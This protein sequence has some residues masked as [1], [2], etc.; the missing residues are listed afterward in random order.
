MKPREKFSK[1]LR[2]SVD[3][4]KINYVEF[5]D[6]LGI[7]ESNFRQW[8]T[9]R[10]LP[11]R[12]IIDELCDELSKKLNANSDNHKNTAMVKLIANV[13]PDF[14]EDDIAG[15]IG[16]Y[17]VAKL[18][19]CFT[20]AKQ[21]K[22]ANTKNTNDIVAEK[23]HMPTGKIQA[24]VFDFDGTLTHKEFT[25]TTWES[26]WEILDY[27]VEEC[28]KLHG[29][30]DKNEITH[31]EWCN[32]TCDKFVEKNLHK[33]VLEGIAKKIKLLDGCKDTFVEL[34]NRNIQIYIVS[35]SILYIV[36][37][38]LGDLVQYVDDIKANLFRFSS[39]GL[40][41]EIIGTKYDF[42]G[43]ADYIREIADS[44]R[45]STAD[46]LF[47]GN[48]YND[49][50]AY[51]SGAKTLCINPSKTNPANTTIWHERIDNCSNLQ[52]ILDCKHLKL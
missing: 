10:S 16:G 8:T 20:N 34:D 15:D 33:S 38:V 21:R 35:G 48:S 30:F 14:T 18:M 7:V 36:Q 40:L 39:N 25:R 32:L 11:G 1:I 28:V 3:L 24:V 45:I 41:T 47:I 22:K 49:E 6:E 31:Q 44:L 52:Q 5:A 9:G 43:K 2:S 23:S 51:R 4:Y 13:C 42:E 12:H 50:F 19:V 46:I 37:R 17:V 29:K 27:D 26:I